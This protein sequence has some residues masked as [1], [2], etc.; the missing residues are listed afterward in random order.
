MRRLAQRWARSFGLLP[1]DLGL[2]SL[3]DLIWPLRHTLE[4]RRAR[5]S[6]ILSRV[7]LVALLF[8][9]LTPGWV[10]IDLMAFP[11][12]L[13]LELIIARL[14]ATLA[15]A[16][17]V[18]VCGRCRPSLPH[19]YA[20]LAGMF[21]VPTLFYVVSYTIVAGFEITG[22]AVT[23]AAGYGFL[24]YVVVAGLSVF[25]LTLAESVIL[26]LPVLFGGV[27]LYITEIELLGWSPQLTSL[28]LLSLVAVTAGLAGMSQLQ[29]M[30]ALVWRSSRDSLTGAMNRRSG[31]EV[32]RLLLS[33]ARRQDQPLT[34]MFIDLDDFKS[35]NDCFGHEE[36]DRVLKQ[37]VMRLEGL[38]RQSDQV[39]RWGGEEF[40][41]VLPNTDLD[42]AAV[43]LSRIQAHGLGQRPD[44]RT[45]TAS[46]GVAEWR[47]DD[48][49]DVNSLVECA[50]ARMYLAKRAG[51]NRWVGQGGVVQLTP[52]PLKDGAVKDVPME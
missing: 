35:V 42:Q 52:A 22:L 44:H 25:P 17:L 33:L 46:I 14:V 28:W 50:D 23:V 27:G 10:V 7:R 26:T 39:I 2:E 8:A 18:V 3:F 38:M 20:A 51:K 36:G 16:G 40:L 47:T 49:T 24:P 32:L 1:E 11:A 45:Q 29:F 6:L 41:V 30:I 43:P 19:A 4:V 13:A 48:L 9:V 31:T 21:L 12:E 34:L 15:F 37:A 5:A